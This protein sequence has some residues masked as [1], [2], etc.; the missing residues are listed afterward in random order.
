MS[1]GA[2]I[3]VHAVN[4]DPH[5]DKKQSLMQTIKT[6]DPPQ[7]GGFMKVLQRMFGH[8]Y[9]NKPPRWQRRQY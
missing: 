6:N 8:E 3:L 5:H 2:S 1:M 7:N 4:R 9:S